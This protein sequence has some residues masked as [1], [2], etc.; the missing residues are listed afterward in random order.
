VVDVNQYEGCS[1]W[2]N[3]DVD[4][5]LRSEGSTM[6]KT[7]TRQRL[8]AEERQLIAML[9]KDRGRMNDQEI[10]LALDQARALGQLLTND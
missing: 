10:E 9:E 6:R 7:T 2:D 1:L 4:A 3:S 5:I 8:T